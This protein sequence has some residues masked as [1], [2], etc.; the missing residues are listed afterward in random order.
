MKKGLVFLLVSF[1]IGNAQYFEGV[2]QFKSEITG[3]NAERLKAMMPSEYVMKFKGKKS[4]I[5]MKGGM[6]EIM[7]MGTT[8]YDGE[9]YTY[10][11]N[12]QQKVA[13]RMDVSEVKK[14]VKEEVSKP[15]IKKLG[16]GETILGY[17]T[18][19][20]EVK[21]NTPQGPITQVMWVAPD[22][23]VE[24]NKAIK[25]AQSF[26]IEGVDGFPLK[27]VQN[28]DQLGIKMILTATQVEKKSLSN[29]EFEIPKDYTVQEFKMD[30]FQTDY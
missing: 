29:S 30:Q 16:P 10:L 21:M 23:V 25:N 28:M 3:E 6:V 22:I 5:E 11:L 24:K 12:P 9:K 13:Q 14:E 27:I 20:Y 7:G 17:K 1:A 2:I 8:I 19:K 4:R 26:M 15:E 18:I